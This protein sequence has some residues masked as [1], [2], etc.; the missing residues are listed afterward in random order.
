MMTGTATSKRFVL[1]A[2][3]KT[4]L[5]WESGD[6]GESSVYP[7]DA[8]IPYSG[9]DTREFLASLE[10]KTQAGVWVSTHGNKI[11]LAW[12]NIHNLQ[13]AVSDIVGTCE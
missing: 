1:D 13:D 2:G 3:S 7:D 10:G 12:F 5:V 4:K 6:D 8:P 9:S 11:I